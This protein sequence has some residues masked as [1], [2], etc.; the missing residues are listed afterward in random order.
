MKN[1]LLLTIAIIALI[2]FSA[3]ACDPGG[4]D[5]VIYELGDTGP[6]G[7]IIFYRDLSGF[8]VQGY[9][10]GA[11][12]FES[13]TARYL[14]AAPSNS[15]TAQWGASETLISNVTTFTST[16]HTDASTIGNGRKDTRIIVNALTSETDRAAQLAAAYQGGEKN[17]WFLPSLGELNLL[18][19]NRDYVGNL[20]T[21]VYWSSSQYGSEFVWVRDFSGGPQ[22]NGLKNESYYVRPIRAF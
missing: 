10:G 20:G 12:S 21:S 17:D 1:K 22:D 9:S 6:G 19:I 2:G 15:G 3:T 7:G 8:T 18:Y 13:Y 5:E 16:S 4:D 11:G 14:E